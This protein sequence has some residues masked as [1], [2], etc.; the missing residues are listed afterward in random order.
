MPRTGTF[1][2]ATAVA[3]AASVSACS[4]A[5][6]YP[7]GNGIFVNSWGRQLFLY[8]YDAAEAQHYPCGPECSPAWTPLFAG[9]YDV[10]FRDFRIMVRDDGNWQWT[11]RG[12]PIYFFSGRIVAMSQDAQVRAGLWEPLTGSFGRQ[13]FA[14]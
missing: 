8:R 4:T 3:L 11:Y 13:G 12:N 14:W 2:A 10:P 5:P 7:A 9:G 6:V 1:I